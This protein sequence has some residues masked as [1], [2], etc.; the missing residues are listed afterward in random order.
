MPYV[1]PKIARKELGVNDQTLRMWSE[2]GRLKS[3][4]GRGGYRLYDIEDFLSNRDIPQLVSKNQIPSYDKTKYIYCRVSTSKQRDDLERQV[5]YLSEKYPTHK[6][7]KEIASGINFKRKAL[8]RILDEVTHGTVS[9]IVVANRDR[10]C[11][12]AWEHFEWL[13]SRYGVNIVVDSKEDK[14]TSTE[15]E[16][17]EDLMSIIHVFSSRHYGKRRKYTKKEVSGDDSEDENAS[18]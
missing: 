3:I 13:F 1:K 12:F 10:L 8:K 16:L 2:E 7:V 4:K 6:I 18:E 14:N 17:A 9:E 15:Q 11:R 5:T